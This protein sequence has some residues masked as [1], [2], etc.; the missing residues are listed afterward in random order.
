VLAR[1]AGYDRPRVQPRADNSLSSAHW[2]SFLTVELRCSVDVVYT[3]ARRTPIQAKRTVAHRG[4]TPGL[5]VRMH[6]MFA[7]APPEVQ[8]AVASWIRSGR[9]APRACAALDAWIAK[10][11]GTLPVPKRVEAAEPRGLHY[12]LAELARQLC[13]AEFAAE[14]PAPDA[15]P[16][17]GWGRRGASRTRHSLRLGSFDPDTKF[18]R[19]HPVLDQTEVPE[20]FVR[21]VL[22]HELLHAVYPPQRDGDDRWVHHGRDF[23][24]RE[25]AYADYERALAWEKRNIRA[26]IRAARRGDGFVAASEAEP[27]HRR[28]LAA[29]AKT[30]AEQ[31][32][33]EKQ[34]SAA[35][36]GRAST[37]TRAGAQGRTKSPASTDAT[38]R[39][40]PRAPRPSEIA[41]ALAREWRQWD[42][43][44]EW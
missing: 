28:G 19:L 12:D 3:R 27:A 44:P 18:V 10:T 21:Y 26:L 43:F 29:A 17:I 16:A 33:A 25:H 41:K 5:E 37:G 14:F 15:L 23:R 40:K 42:L 7:G 2:R 39:P 9:R 36:Q 32:S 11:L 1:N 24:R 20:Y 13:A 35:A 38:A 22:F 34:S 6:A 30:S 31:T 4:A 8:R